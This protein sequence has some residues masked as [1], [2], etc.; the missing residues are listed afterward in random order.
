M[1]NNDAM[2]MMN[3]DPIECGCYVVHAGF[4]LD[5]QNLAM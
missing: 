5:V 1:M 2:M 3:D 4:A